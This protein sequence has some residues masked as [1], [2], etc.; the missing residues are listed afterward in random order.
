MDKRQADVEEYEGRTI[1]PIDNG[2]DSERMSGQIPMAISK[3]LS[4]PSLEEKTLK[5]KMAVL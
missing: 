5:A 2:F 1:K 4:I 3:S